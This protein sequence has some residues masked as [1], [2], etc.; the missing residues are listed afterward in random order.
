M[1]FNNINNFKA[2]CAIKIS[3]SIVCP[4]RHWSERVPSLKLGVD[5]AFNLH[6]I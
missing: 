4:R 5:G 2:S 3:D 1:L 6:I